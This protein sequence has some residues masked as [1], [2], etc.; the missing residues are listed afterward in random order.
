MQA[1][2]NLLGVNGRNPRIFFAFFWFAW[3]AILIPGH[4]RGAI[5]AGASCCHCA[6]QN[7]NS[8]M[9]ANRS[10]TNCAVCQ[11]AAHLMPAIV[12]PVVLQKG[13]LIEML[14]L[15]P[16]QRPNLSERPL[17]FLSRGPPSLI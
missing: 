13:E 16:A 7:Q 1:W 12:V 14:A 9:P 3:T 4:T 2:T 15:A 6:S 17:C 5:P 10:P 8:K 11:L